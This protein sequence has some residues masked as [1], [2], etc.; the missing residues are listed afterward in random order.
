MLDER[1]GYCLWVLRLACGVQPIVSGLR[2]F[3]TGEPLGRIEGVIELVAGVLVFTPLTKATA[4]F[5]TAWLL[6]LA[7]RALSGR[8]AYDVAIW[9]ILLAAGAFALVRLTQV[10]E[11][12]V[13][14]APSSPRPAEP[15]FRSAA[16]PHLKGTSLPNSPVEEPLAALIEAAS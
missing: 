2:K 14:E 10:N 3:A 5:L 9:D 6:L 1:L 11:A 13:A 7:L 15:Q 16:A 8:G 12:A 4:R